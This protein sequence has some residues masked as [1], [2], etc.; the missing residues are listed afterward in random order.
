MWSETRRWPTSAQLLSAS[1]SK[2][3]LG[4]SR[5]PYS[6]PYTPIPASMSEVSRARPQILFCQ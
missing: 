6:A 2:R 4:Q 3:H 1:C 5:P